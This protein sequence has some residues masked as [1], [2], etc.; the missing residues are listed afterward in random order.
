M[1]HRSEYWLCP[2]GRDRR[3]QIRLQDI[4]LNNVLE[5]SAM[6]HCTLAEEPLDL[7][8]VHISSGWV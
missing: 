7:D 2:F 6:Y 4:Q 1:V 5:T 8:V 3:A